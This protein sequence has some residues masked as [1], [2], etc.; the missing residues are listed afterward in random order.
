MSWTGNDTALTPQEV[1]LQVTR[2]LSHIVETIRG[3]MEK[4]L[5][6]LMSDL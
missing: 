5:D 3:E 4:I 1:F 6:H 2:E